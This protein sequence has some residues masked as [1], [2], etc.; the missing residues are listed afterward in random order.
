MSLFSTTLLITNPPV[1][2]VQL[3]FTVTVPNF[4]A[5]VPVSLSTLTLLYPAFVCSSVRSSSLTAYL[6][7]T[8]SPVIVRSSAAVTVFFRIPSSV[9]SSVPFTVTFPAYAFPSAFFR[10]IVIWNLV[11]SFSFPSTTFWTLN[12]PVSGFD[13]LFVTTMIWSA[14]AV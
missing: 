7:P 13:T 2:C 3:L 1:G 5:T 6:V 4:L 9:V 14:S 8:G 11:V 12:P 10:V